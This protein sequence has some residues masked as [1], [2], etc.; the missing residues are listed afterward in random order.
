[1]LAGLDPM[2]PTDL[3]LLGGASGGEVHRRELPQTQ[4][5]C[6]DHQLSLSRHGHAVWLV[7]YLNISEYDIRQKETEKNDR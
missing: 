2:S 1:M 4:N 3:S 7:V 5:F 6:R